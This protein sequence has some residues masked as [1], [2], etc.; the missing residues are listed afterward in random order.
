M[1]S[2]GWT[3]FRFT[4]CFILKGRPLVGFLICY[5]LPLFFFVSSL[6][7]LCFP[8]FGLLPVL[9]Q[10]WAL[11]CF[12]FS[13]SHTDLQTSQQPSGLDITWPLA[14]GEVSCICKE[15]SC[16]ESLCV[17]ALVAKRFAGVS[18]EWHHVCLS[19][20]GAGWVCKCRLTSTRSSRSASWMIGRKLTKSL[21]T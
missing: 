7:S 15:V 18:P 11:Q 6:L 9:F 12:Y 17:T 5:F 2:C 13:L 20:S 3:L 21:I 10:R 8:S 4:S 14:L 1:S 16:T 19:K